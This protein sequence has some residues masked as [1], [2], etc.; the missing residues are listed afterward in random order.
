MFLYFA[1]TLSQDFLIKAFY[2]YN[3]EAYS[4]HFRLRLIGAVGR[5]DA[6]Q[7]NNPNFF[8][9]INLTFIGCY[10]HMN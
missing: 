3:I 9:F 1:A 8:K 7:I 5:T 6:E 2:R 4:I 10:S